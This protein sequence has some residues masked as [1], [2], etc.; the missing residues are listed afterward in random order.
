VTSGAATP[1]RDALR[2]LFLGRAAA[3]ERLAAQ[4]DRLLG[5]G[6]PALIEGEPGTGKTLLASVVHQAARRGSLLTLAHPVADDALREAARAGVVLCEEVATFAHEAQEELLRL[7]RAPGRQ[8]PLLLAT[9]RHDLDAA[10]AAGWFL[11]ELRDRLHV[12]RL[13]L[14]SLREHP[15]AVAELL[16]AALRARRAPDPPPDVTPDALTALCAYG[17][18][19]NA[20]ELEEAAR[21]LLGWAPRGPIERAHVARFVGQLGVRAGDPGAPGPKAR[22][23]ERMEAP[24]LEALERATIAARLGEHEWRQAETARSLGIDRKTLYRK[25]RQ[26]G[27]TP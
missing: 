25:I 20:R 19:G 11:P 15:P 8:T 27:L 14:P 7:L 6:L 24:T 2:Q 13:R 22:A 9:T 10:V 3:L 23:S 21:V 1:A 12:V 16:L 18:P 26:Y 5:A 17:W 4:V